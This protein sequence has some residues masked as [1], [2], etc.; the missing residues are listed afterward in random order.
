MRNFPIPL[1]QNTLYIPQLPHTYLKVIISVYFATRKLLFLFPKVTVGW[2]HIIKINILKIRLTRVEH[3]VIN[4]LCP[5]SDCQPLAL[6]F[7]ISPCQ[8][9]FLLTRKYFKGKH[10]QS[11]M[12]ETILKWMQTPNRLCFSCLLRGSY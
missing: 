1:K 2:C 5:F 6:M 3:I 8:S 11:I 7:K 4:L 10:L 12:N 9:C